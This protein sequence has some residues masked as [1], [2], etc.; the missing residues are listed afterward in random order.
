M[1]TWADVRFAHLLNK[2]PAPVKHYGKTYAI[3]CWKD[4]LRTTVAV[5]LASGVLWV[6]TILVDDANAMEPFLVTYLIL[7]I[8]FA[9]DV[10]GAVYYTVWPK[11]QLT[12]ST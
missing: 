10:L 4:V 5:A 3:D 9:S 7:G 8:W 1:V 2:G 11:K 12:S 6:L